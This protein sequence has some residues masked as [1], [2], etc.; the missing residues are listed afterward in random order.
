MPKRLW[1]VGG[2][3]PDLQAEVAFHRQMGHEVVIEREEGQIE[4]RPQYQALI[5][6]G[7]KQLVLAEEWGM[8]SALSEPLPYGATHFS[9]SVD[10]LDAERAAALAAGASLLHGP[11]I[12]QGGWGKR[13]V[14]CFQS[15]GGF[16]FCVFEVI[17]N[18]VPEV[19]FSL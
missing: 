17:E 13:R 11:D 18:T 2:K 15:R 7:D 4:G 10:D 12:I 6:V 16:P 5:K 9:H 8:E 3:F 14:A 1:N 19:Q